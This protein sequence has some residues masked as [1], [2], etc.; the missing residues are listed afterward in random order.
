[1]CRQAYQHTGDEMLSNYVISLQKQLQETEK[2]VLGTR[3][4]GLDRTVHDIKS[5]DYVYVRSF[6]DSPLE[7]KWEGPFQVLLTSH[8]AI[9]IKE[10][11]LWIHHTRVKR[12]PDKRWTSEPL[13]SRILA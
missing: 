9:K 11:T 12:A 2:M 10:Q 1:M 3:A 13:G 7:P 4:Q 6:T 5:G 8:T